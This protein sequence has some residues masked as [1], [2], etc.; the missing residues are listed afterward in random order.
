MM[1]IECVAIFTCMLLASKPYMM[2]YYLR[3][4]YNGVRKKQN[5][6]IWFFWRKSIVC[7][8]PEGMAEG[9]GIRIPLLD[10]DLVAFAASTLPVLSNL[11]RHSP[12]IIKKSSIT[13]K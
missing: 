9:V 6:L 3:C 2:L 7:G 5:W 11:L 1:L 13:N 4:F 10:P 8:N 12:R